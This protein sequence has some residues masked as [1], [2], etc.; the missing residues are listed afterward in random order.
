VLDLWGRASCAR[1]RCR[2]RPRLPRQCL[3][4]SFSP[5][6]TLAAERG[7]RHLRPLRFYDGNGAP[8][9]FPGSER[10]LLSGLETLRRSST[11][12]ALAKRSREA[13]QHRAGARAGWL[14]QLLTDTLTAQGLLG[15]GT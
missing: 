1:A 4:G 5:P 11:M 8:L 10:L 9:A 12:I 13:G 3:H 15:A 14:N 2:G 6:T 7:R